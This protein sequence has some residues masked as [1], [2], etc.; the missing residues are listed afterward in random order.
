[1]FV[2]SDEQIMGI[3]YRACGKGD[4]MHKLRILERPEMCRNYKRVCVGKFFRLILTHEGQLF[5]CGQNKKYM[6][7]KDIDTNAH[8]DK[9]V[10]VKDLFPIAS[11]DKIIDVDGGKHFMIVVTQK[12]KVFTSGYMMYRAVSEI[13]SNTEENEDYPCE[14]KMSS[15]TEGWIPKQCWACDLYCNVWI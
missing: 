2:S 13:R 11:D 1:M 4:D 3:G 12:G 5:F 8:V 15:V 7:G 6:I 9:F 14:L 10:E